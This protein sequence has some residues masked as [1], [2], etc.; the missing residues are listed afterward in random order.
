MG[1]G[2]RTLNRCKTRVDARSQLL[3]LWNVNDASS[4]AL[5]AEFYR[6][7]LTKGKSKAEALRQAK[8]AMLYDYDIKNGVMRGTIRTRNKNA[9]APAR[10]ATSANE[11]ALLAAR[12]WA[13]FVLIGDWR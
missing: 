4:A 9:S 5:I 10:K 8:L 11:Q 12:F 13:G 3:T 6:E 1:Q 2:N 7:F